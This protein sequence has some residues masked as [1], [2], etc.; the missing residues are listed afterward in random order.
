MNLEGDTE[1]LSFVQ[2]E[3]IVS[4]Y[5]DATFVPYL[6]KILKLKAKSNL[7]LGEVDELNKTI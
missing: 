3:R 1:L 5:D 2:V 6:F 4:K 7:N